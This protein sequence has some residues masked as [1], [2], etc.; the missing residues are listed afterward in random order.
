MGASLERGDIGQRF[1]HHVMRDALEH[2]QPA[3]GVQHGLLGLLRPQV[4]DQQDPGGAVLG[5]LL[6]NHIDV[7]LRD[8]LAHAGLQRVE[9]RH[10]LGIELAQLPHG[11]LALSL[12]DDDQVDDAD[13]LLLDQIED[14]RQ[15]LAPEPIA[16]E[17]QCDQIDGSVSH[18]FTF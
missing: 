1:I 10:V 17:L 14:L 11:H 6:R 15:D 9:Y 5:E 3:V 16:G 8:H 2:H 13:D 4:L 7:A 12:H 18:W